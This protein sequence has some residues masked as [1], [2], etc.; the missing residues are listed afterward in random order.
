MRFFL[1][2]RSFPFVSVWCALAVFGASLFPVAI[3]QAAEF[4]PFLTLKVAGPS[5][6]INLAEK[7]SGIA[8][9]T[10]MLGVK[11]MLAPYKNL[12]GMNPNGMI[13]LACQVNENSSLLGLD[14]VVAL[15]I[16]NV[17]TFNIPGQ[18]MSIGLLKSM[19]QK[20][21]S[22]CRWLHMMNSSPL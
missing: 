18:E 5:A 17:E 19:L 6:V 1:L 12:P 10:G 14:L 22:W 8:D 2:C 16:A 3:T 21:G 4:K 9:P 11:A 20:E 15:P 7:I 13:G